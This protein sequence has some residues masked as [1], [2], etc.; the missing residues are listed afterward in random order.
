MQ[1]FKGVL[2]SRFSLQKFGFL[3]PYRTYLAQPNYISQ[4]D[5]DHEQD[6][7]IFLVNLSCL[8]L[9]FDYLASFKQYSIALLVQISG[10]S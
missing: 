5:H 3:S 4:N 10:F 1:R 2:D 6:Q 8:L 7:V 9:F